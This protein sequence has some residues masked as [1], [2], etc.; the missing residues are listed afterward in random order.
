[1][2]KVIVTVA[3]VGSIPTRE[4][5]AH[6][7]ITPEEIG[8]EARR[9]VEAGA[10]IVHLHVRDP[11]SGEPTANA[12]VF[13]AGLEAV[14][15]ETDA[16]TQIT[17]GGGATT[18]GLGPEERLQAVLD[19][20]P[21]MA[22]LNAGSVNFGR[23]VFSNPTEVIEMYAREM[24]RAGVMPEFEIYERGMIE[25]VKKLVLGPGLIKCR[26]RMSFVLGIQGGCPASVDDLAHM[27]S[28]LPPDTSW[29]IIAIG[30][31]QIPLGAVGVVMGGD[32]RVGMED[33]LYLEKG[34]LATSN[35]ELVEKMV[36]VIRELGREP[37]SPSEAR[38]Q[39]GLL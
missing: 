25:N 28:C 31:H 2:R 39:L 17:T 32:V 8:A 20:K 10:A 24:D 37:A 22:S 5:S 18:L 30:R 21:E 29:Q 13:R 34:V 36:R 11:Q 35:A 15:A 9:S 4:D 16:V 6:I 14:R 38:K 33:N 19:L 27:R 3:P 23:K 7:P 12:E 1:M 26:T